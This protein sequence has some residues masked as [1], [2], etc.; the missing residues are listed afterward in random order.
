MSFYL[1]LLQDYLKFIQLHELNDYRACHQIN[2]NLLLGFIDFVNEQ[3][4]QK[5]QT[6][7]S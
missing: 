5:Y 2:Q 4:Y 7:V 3:K 1:N 6:L